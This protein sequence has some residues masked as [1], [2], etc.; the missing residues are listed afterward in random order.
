MYLYKGVAAC[1]FAGVSAL[2]SAIASGGRVRLLR[3]VLAGTSAPA[4]SPFG[5]RKMDQ[6]VQIVM[7]VFGLIGIGYLVALSGLVGERTGDALSE[8]VFTIA[9]PALLFRV[10]AQADLSTGTPWALWAGYYVPF[11][12]CWLGG[13]LLARRAFGRDARAGLV[14]GVSSAYSNGLLIGLPVIIA[15]FGPSGATAAAL[16]ITI[17]TP[18][19]MAVSAVLMERATLLD[20]VS[21]G[22]SPRL[23]AKRLFNSLVR[24]SVLIGVALG[25]FWHFAGLPFGGPAGTI[26]SKIADAAST[27]ALL[28]V[29]MTLRKFGVRGNVVAA[30]ALSAFKLAAMPVL[31]FL[32]LRYAFDLPQA[33][34]AA[35]VIFAACPT[36]VNAYLIAQRFG[37]GQGLASSIITISTA[38]SVITIT[39]WLALLQGM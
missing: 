13:T 27:L 12:I 33:W 8:F 10:L 23:V 15:A 37:T 32:L 16:L 9:M 25:L 2:R 17:H 38:L 22:V 1:R 3:P 4:R 34:V 14:A 36:G 5:F 39:V 29:G 6:I 24:N 18:L 30:I 19:T 26:V 20:G 31:V 21:S 7:P 11:A 28:A 35:A